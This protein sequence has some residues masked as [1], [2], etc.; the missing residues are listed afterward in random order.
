MNTE[1]WVKTMLQNKKV[2]Y[3]MNFTEEEMEMLREEAKSRD[4]PICMVIR[5]ALDAYFE[6]VDYDKKYVWMRQN[7]WTR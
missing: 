4:I 6:Q 5:D 1:K 7:Y 3:H 2:S